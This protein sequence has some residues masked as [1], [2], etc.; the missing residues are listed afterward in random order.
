MLSTKG[1]LSVFVDKKCTIL[2]ATAMEL[3][4][5]TIGLQHEFREWF[6]FT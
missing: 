5:D 2:V 4:T 3:I 6:D 1:G